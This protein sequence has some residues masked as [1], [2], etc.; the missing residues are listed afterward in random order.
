MNYSFSMK[1]TENKKNCILLILFLCLWIFNF[2]SQRIIDHQ[3]YD[4]WRK[5]NNEQ[6]SHDGSILTYELNPFTGDG[7][8][9]I[10]H[11]ELNKSDTFFLSKN[12][13]ISSMSDMVGF[14]KYEFR[15]M[16]T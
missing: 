9:I 3:C 4:N 8:L 7:E 16:L 14:K 11:L 15:L 5:I 2:N 13:I 12:A 6:L 10:E 1:T